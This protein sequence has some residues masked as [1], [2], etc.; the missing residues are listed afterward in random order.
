[1]KFIKFNNL[2]VLEARYDDEIH[3]DKI[4]KGSI[5]VSDEL[6]WKTINENDGVWKLVDNNIVKLPFPPPTA[7][8]KLETATLNKAALMFVADKAVSKYQDMVDV[9]DASA[10]E[11]AMLKKWKQYRVVLHRLDLAANSIVWPIVPE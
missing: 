10:E 4:P 2:N 7:E 11:K 5:K 6:F 8:E 3:G 1:M 9:S